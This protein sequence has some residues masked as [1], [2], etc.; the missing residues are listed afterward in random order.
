[1]S[2]KILNL[3]DLIRVFSQGLRGFDCGRFSMNSKGTFCLVVLL[4]MGSSLSFSDTTYTDFKVTHRDFSRDVG[5]DPNTHRSGP[6]PSQYW[7]MRNLK[8]RIRSIGE[9][10]R[11]TKTTKDNDSEYSRGSP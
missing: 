8:I 6:W 7:P 9:R 3:S 2:T 11:G 1:M 10:H 5:P 4:G